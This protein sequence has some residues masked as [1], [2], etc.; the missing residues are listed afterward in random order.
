MSGNKNNIS[1]K[2]KLNTEKTK[3]LSAALAQ[4]EKQ[5]Q[6]LRTKYL[7]A[8]NPDLQKIRTRHKS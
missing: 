8:R 3:A 7:R 4:I 5:L 2:T 6:E 1:N